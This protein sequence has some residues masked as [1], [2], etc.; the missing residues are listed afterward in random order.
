MP[1]ADSF[2]AI[3]TRDTLSILSSFSDAHLHARH[4]ADDQSTLLCIRCEPEPEL[5][6]AEWLGPEQLSVWPGPEQITATATRRRFCEICH[7]RHEV[8]INDF[9]ESPRSN[10]H[11]D[12]EYD[13]TPRRMILDA[14]HSPIPDMWKQIL[15]TR[16]LTTG[17]LIPSRPGSNFAWMRFELDDVSVHLPEKFSDRDFC[18][19]DRWYKKGDFAGPFYH[20]TKV[21]SLIQG[22]EN[23]PGSCGI[24]TGKYLDSRDEPRRHRGNRSAVLNYGTCTHDR[25]HG[26]NFYTDG[27]TETFSEYPMG[28]TDSAL[29]WCSLELNVS[30]ATKLRGGRSGRY[31]ISQV[32][33]PGCEECQFVG[34][35]AILFPVFHLPDFFLLA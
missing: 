21:T 8:L 15:E 31:C 1:I 35:K 7:W 28:T 13:F 34:I 30:C 23:A 11:D 24:L 26:V 14:L 2:F 29:A 27:G 6:S 22:H 19:D 16:S 10:Y 25:I 32:L 4:V 20:N 9:P 18:I 33:A 5:S 3:P 17:R 12:G